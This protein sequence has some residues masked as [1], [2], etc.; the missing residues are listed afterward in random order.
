[1]HDK[2]VSGPPRGVAP[3]AR[4]RPSLVHLVAGQHVEDVR[5]VKVGV[6]RPAPVPVVALALRVRVVYL[7]VKLVD[8]TLYHAHVNARRPAYPV[9]RAQRKRAVGPHRQ[10]V[11]ALVI[12]FRRPLYVVAQVVR[13]AC[14]E[15][16][17]PR[18]G[19]RLVGRSRRQHE[20]VRRLVVDAP[21][22]V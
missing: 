4:N 7:T 13:N 15:M 8:K 11:E 3:L 12:G 5:L 9:A 18:V 22:R 16:T 1:M 19:K 10:P 14:N 20:Q 17:G 6:I 2:P 21:G